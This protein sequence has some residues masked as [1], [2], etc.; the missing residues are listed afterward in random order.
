MD[1]DTTKLAL[2]EYLKPLNHKFLSDHIQKHGL[3]RY[4][5]K[6]DSIR[7]TKL[8]VFAQLNQIH[9]YTDLSSHVR[10]KRKLQ[11]IVGLPSIST[12]QLSRKWRDLDSSFMAEVFHHMVQRVITEFGIVKS[13]KKLGVLNLIDA[14]TIS[15][16]L[17]KYRWATL[18]K[19]KS[20]VKLHLRFVH[21]SESISYPEEVTI[22]EAK[23]NERTEMDSIIV[24]ESGALNVFDRGY[25]DYQKYDRYC[26][27]EVRFVTRLRHNADY[28]IVEELPVEADAKIVKDSVIWLGYR[29]TRYIM[30]RHLRL[31]ECLDKDGKPFTILTNDFNLPATEIGDIYRNR[32]QIELFFKWIKQHLHIKSCYG[33]SRNAV[34]NQ[35]YAALI[36]FCLTLLMQSR[37]GHKGSLLEVLKHLTLNWEETLQ[38]FIRGLFRPPEKKSLGRPKGINVERI[39]QEIMHQY[40]SD[41][42]DYLDDMMMDSLI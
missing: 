16:C 12:S 35:I 11:R 14:S 7:I 9:S 10:Q 6:L 24:D 17:S 32:W 27:N 31:I 41:G 25:V 28:K 23:R 5:K 22:T 29:N 26:E 42:I 18:S 19:H 37:I 36:T 34:H 15:L 3:D 8:F 30:K 33:T 2:T 4:V 40:E 38:I 39:Y 21:T 13:N 20:G 1:K